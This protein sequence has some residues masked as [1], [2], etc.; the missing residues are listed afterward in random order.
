MNAM[1]KEADQKFLNNLIQRTSK[2]EL[3]WFC[4]QN[5]DDPL[6]DPHSYICYYPIRMQIN[7]N[8]KDLRAVDFYLYPERLVIIDA[9][10]VW[11]GNINRGKIEVLQEEEDTSKNYLTNPL[12]HVVLKFEKEDYP[13]HIERLLALAEEQRIVKNDQRYVNLV[14]GFL[15]GQ[16]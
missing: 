13:T 15:K 1:R 4:E 11:L 8:P 14:S 6:Y 16:N 3:S 12:D 10:Y 5:E 9:G 7:S 2:N